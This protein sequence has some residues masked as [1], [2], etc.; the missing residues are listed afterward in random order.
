MVQKA[1]CEKN[2]ILGGEIFS[3]LKSLFSW[4]NNDLSA[5]T[6]VLILEPIGSVFPEITMNE[7]MKKR[8]LGKISQKKFVQFK[9]NNLKSNEDFKFRS[10]SLEK[11]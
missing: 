8:Y 7:L 6:L 9:T 5:K 1:E 2:I 11:N 4:L 10:K 3:F